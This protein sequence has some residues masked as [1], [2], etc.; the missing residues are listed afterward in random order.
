[1]ARPLFF[2][3]SHRIFNLQKLS[4]HRSPLVKT[5]FTVK[6]ITFSGVAMLDSGCSTCIVP[7]SRLPK[8]AKKHVTHSDVHIK[9]I[10]GSITAFGELYCN[11]N[12][13][14]RDSPIFEDI[15]VLVTTQDTS[16]LIGQNILA[17]NTLDSYII[18]NQNAT[19]EFRRTLALGYTVHTA[20]IIPTSTSPHGPAYGALTIHNNNQPTIGPQ[21]NIQTLDQKLN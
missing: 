19:V 10:N 21:P 20:P 9:G 6:G 2:Y 4:L 15:N 5:T 3:P 16:I 12:I 7:I 18:D 11:I 17:H 13:G 14:N 1:M 8:E